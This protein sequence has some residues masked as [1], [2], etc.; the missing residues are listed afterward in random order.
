MY[1]TPKGDSDLAQGGTER[2]PRETNGRSNTFDPQRSGSKLPQKGNR[3]M[4]FD[5]N[6]LELPPLRG[7]IHFKDRN[8]LLRVPLR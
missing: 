2:N 5:A 1:E 4:P 3:D 6:T 7:S 8:H